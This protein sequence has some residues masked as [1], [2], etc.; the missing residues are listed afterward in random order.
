M[1]KL[2]LAFA[3]VVSSGAVFAADVPQS[4]RFDNRIQYVN[5]NEGDVVVVQTMAGRGARLVFAPNETVI[6]IASGFSQGWEF[7]DS[8]NVVY[9]KAKSVK[10]ENGDRKSVV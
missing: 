10:G 4:S 8:G 6:D 2:T 3:L 9:L 1:N 7:P 5:Y